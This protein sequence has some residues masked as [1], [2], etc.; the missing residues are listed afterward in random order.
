M[1]KLILLTCLFLIGCNEHVSDFHMGDRVRVKGQQNIGV[2]EYN[3]FSYYKITVVFTD[4]GAAQILQI[5][6]RMLEKVDTD[7]QTQ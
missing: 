7:G 2:V 3:D 6:K 4:N 5:D 1:N